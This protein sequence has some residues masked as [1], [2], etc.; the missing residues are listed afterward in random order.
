[1]VWIV[2][3]LGVVVVDVD[4]GLIIGIGASIVAVFIEDQL[5]EVR[6]LTEYYQASAFV[7]EALV[8]VDQTILSVSRKVLIRPYNYI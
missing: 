6:T 2:T 8:S 1:M 7:N 4:Y 5:V 3:F